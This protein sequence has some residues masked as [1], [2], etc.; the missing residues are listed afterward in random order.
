M[1]GK[2]EME[3]HFLKERDIPGV[4]AFRHRKRFR[5]ITERAVKKRGS[6]VYHG[7]GAP[8]LASSVLD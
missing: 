4:A 7:N 1:P 5:G 3:K 8:G 2:L 6:D